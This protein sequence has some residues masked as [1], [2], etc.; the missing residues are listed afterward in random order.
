M[1][2]SGN[3]CG[4]KT[5]RLLIFLIDFFFMKYLNKRPLKFQRKLFIGKSVN[6][7]TNTLHEKSKSLPLI[8]IC[9]GSRFVF[10]SLNWIF[11]KYDL[12]IYLFINL[13]IY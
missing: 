2:S 6:K 12:F 3:L 8:Q 11:P 10:Y 5:H 4:N 7:S 1:R 13:F 9:F